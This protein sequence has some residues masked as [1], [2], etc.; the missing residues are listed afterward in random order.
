MATVTVSA[1]RISSMLNN[2]NL[3][4]SDL[5]LVGLSVDPE[6]LVA[7]DSDVSFED[8]VALGQRFSKPWSF[9]LVDEA[10]VYR[11][12]GQDNRS[13]GNRR[14]PPSP[15]MLEVIE[16]VADMLEAATELF[17]D[18]KYEVPPVRINTGR[19]ARSDLVT[20][21]EI[22]RRLKA[23]PR[24]TALPPSRHRLQDAQPRP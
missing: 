2:R 14:E 24:Q 21:K 9:F 12:T 15:D 5:A 13:I 1:L 18:T 10:E 11:S 8:L 20:S 6:Q 7:S 4:P 17:P 22:R 23:L 16:T 3:A 19:A